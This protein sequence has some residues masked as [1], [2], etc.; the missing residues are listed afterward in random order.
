MPE[1]CDDDLDDDPLGCWLLP[2][3]TVALVLF[4]YSAIVLFSYSAM[5]APLYW[6]SS[7]QFD[8]QSAGRARY[9]PSS[10]QFDLQFANTASDATVDEAVLTAVGGRN[11]IGTV[12]LWYGAPVNTTTT[13]GLFVGFAAPGEAR[14]LEEI[15]RQ[16]ATGIALVAPDLSVHSTNDEAQ[17]VIG[18][19]LRRYHTDKNGV[20]SAEVKKDLEEKTSSL[21]SLRQLLK[22]EGASWATFHLYG[23]AAAIPLVKCGAELVIDPDN[24]RTIETGGVRAL[25][26]DRDGRVV[27]VEASELRLVPASLDSDPTCVGVSGVVPSVSTD[28]RRRGYGGA[29]DEEGALVKFSTSRSALFPPYHVLMYAV[30]TPIQKGK[31][32]TSAILTKV[33]KNFAKAAESAPELV[34]SLA[35]GLG[36]AA[37]SATK[38][39]AKPTSTPKGSK[40]EET[41]AAGLTKLL[42][43]DYRGKM[44]CLVGLRP[45][46]KSDTAQLG[47]ELIP[48]MCG[49]LECTPELQRST[50]LMYMYADG[51]GAIYAQTTISK[52]TMRLQ[53]THHKGYNTAYPFLNHA[54][55]LRLYGTHRIAPPTREVLALGAVLATVASFTDAKLEPCLGGQKHGVTGLPMQEYCTSRSTQWR[56][57]QLVRH[58]LA[59]AVVLRLIEALLGDH[60]VNLDFDESV[61]TAADAFAFFADIY[62]GVEMSGQLADAYELLQRAR[63][64]GVLE[65]SGLIFKRCTDEHHKSGRNAYES[66]GGPVIEPQATFFGLYQNEF[67]Q[68]AGRKSVPAPWRVKCVQRL[69]YPV[70]MEDGTTMDKTHKD[71]KKKRGGGFPMS[72]MCRLITDYHKRFKELDMPAFKEYSE[73]WVAPLEAYFISIGILPFNIITTA[74]QVHDLFPAE[75][76]EIEAFYDRVVLKTHAGLPTF[77]GA[78]GKGGVDDSALTAQL[79][80]TAMGTGTPFIGYAFGGQDQTRCKLLHHLEYS[81]SKAANRETPGGSVGVPDMGAVKSKSSKSFAAGQAAAKKKKQKKGADSSDDEDEEATDSPDEGTSEG[82]VRPQGKK[83]GSSE[84]VMPGQRV[85]AKIG[86]AADGLWWEGTVTKAYP[87][88]AFFDV[89]YDD[90]DDFE[91]KKPRERVRLM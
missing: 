27:D 33:G 81:H 82:F 77:P 76:E 22:A 46:F 7:L 87:N 78:G 66:D 41:M 68:P 84:K 70:L 91:P 16:V 60:D 49:C 55:L 43:D 52:T 67:H 4:S 21:I 20:V 1:L 37:S 28:G 74:Y 54:D 64:K 3:C 34:A 47:H 45:R 8:L 88:G 36:A 48:L 19:A 80:S 2:L 85:W 40:S 29:R 14:A 69:F 23:A 83:L 31:K 44:T 6:P 17:S 50:A 42:R 79:F 24:A 71:Y 89:R 59:T 90:D 32:A 72:P 62:P 38:Q 57:C 73:N 26:A 51:P 10:L 11:D 12:P 65:N 63:P 35:V 9:W 18:D 75:E 53:Q 25:V 15:T 39:A 13:N 86:D 5:V 30:E 61:P 58:E 56:I